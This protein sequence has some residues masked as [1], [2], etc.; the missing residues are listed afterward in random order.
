[1]NFLITNQGQQK[2][3]GLVKTVSNSSQKYDFTTSSQSENTSLQNI[4]LLNKFLSD[5]AIF[6]L[7]NDIINHKNVYIYI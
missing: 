1:M 6:Q 2:P 7:L 5:P 3:P 4:E